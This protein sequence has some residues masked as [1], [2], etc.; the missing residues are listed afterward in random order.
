[1]VFLILALYILLGGCSAQ[2]AV[3]IRSDGSGEADIKIVLDPVFNAYL[4]DLTAT[5]GRE[6]E[7][8]SPGGSVFDLNLLNES[9]AAEPGLTLVEVHTPSPGE[10]DLIVEF[11]SLALLFALRGSRLA[12]AFRFERTDS[13]RRLAVRIDRRAIENLVNLVGIDP[14]VSESLLPPE[15]DMT[16]AEYRDYLVWALEEYEDDRPIAEVINN[17]AVET[18]VVPAGRV[19][20]VTGG[21]RTGPS[22]FF[23]TPLLEAVTTPVPM[24]YSL[25]FSP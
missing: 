4:A 5:L 10:L 13:F 7:T 22:V 25:I 6:G 14:F 9:F 12:G 3:T 24:D 16:A 1:M 21:T 19:H 15:G 11:E 17:S 23:T 18:R 2:Q 20:Q 8:D